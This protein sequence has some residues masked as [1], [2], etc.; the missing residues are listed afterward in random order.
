MDKL[1]K[2]WCVLLLAGSTWQASAQRAINAAGGTYND[3]ASYYHFEW[4]IGELTL[5][6]ALAPLDSIV[7]FTHGVL[8]PCTEYVTKSN[9]SVLFGPGEYRL[10][11]NP[12]S[13][14]FEL[15]FFVRETGRMELQ[16]TD[17]NGKI[18]EKRDYQYDGCCR[19][20]YFDLTRYPSGTYYVIA[21]LSPDRKRSDNLHI[22]RH[23]GFRV[24]KVDNK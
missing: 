18:L 13:G 11:P 20:E 22:I 24:V 10:F 3:P 1:Y 8:Q 5:I 17:G 23:S 12:T 2:A 4:S 16:L 9:L 14:K 21:R 15:D 7:L 6:D 19:I